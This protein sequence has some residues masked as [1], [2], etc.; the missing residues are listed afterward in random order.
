LR[1][2]ATLD[3]IGAQVSSL[4]ELPSMRPIERRFLTRDELI[5]RLKEELDEDR[6]EIYESQRLYAALGAMEDDQELFDILLSL[7]GEGVLGFYEAEEERFFVVKDGDEFS[8]LQ[9]RTYAHEYIHGV[10]QQHFDFQAI[11][12]G[13]EGNS[14]AEFAL[15]ALIEGDASLGT[16]RYLFEYMSADERAAAD[17]PANVSLNRIFRSAPH[18]IQREYVFPYSEGT[19]FVSTLYQQG[20]WQAVNEAFVRI[21]Q[22]TEQV[23]HPDKYSSGEAPLE[24]TLTDLLPVLG[25]GWRLLAEDTLGE[26]V[27]RAYLETGFYTSNA[28]GAAAGWGGDRVSV[29]IGPQD[30][31]VLLLTALWDTERDAEEFFETFM[32]FTSARTGGEWES[33]GVET[34]QLTLVDEVITVTLF[35]AATTVIVAP[36]VPMS[37]AVLAALS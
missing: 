13:L 22:S 19:V 2:A 29:Y 18:V 32:Q 8:P 9:A 11:R 23:L 37:D 3:E 1:L 27:L 15:R 4:R 16:T 28:R 17:P 31:A 21:P 6:D 7:L 25:E 24:V 10:Q 34:R 14:D 5:A 12:D 33:L 36:N 30:E 20:G 35:N 26:M